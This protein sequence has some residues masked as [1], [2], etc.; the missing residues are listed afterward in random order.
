MI[1][2]EIGLYEI[3][4]ITRQDLSQSDLDRVTQEITDKIN[5]VGGKILRKEYWGLRYL[6]YR[7]KNNSRGHYVF[8]VVNAPKSKIAEIEKRTRFLN[9]IIRYNIISIN[10]FIDEPSHMLKSMS[11]SA[12][13]N[14]ATSNASA[15]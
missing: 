3:V 1:S 14:V 7:I 8:L 4:F 11:D 12:S 2:S 13:D 9:E 6:A 15:S 10:T 5:L